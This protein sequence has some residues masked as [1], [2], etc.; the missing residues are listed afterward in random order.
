MDF[1]ARKV[2]IHRGTDDR[3]GDGVFDVQNSEEIIASW[4]L[5]LQETPA[6]QCEGGS[7]PR[8]N[9]MRDVGRH[10]MGE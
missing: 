1:C 7:N 3:M 9:H 8:G 4:S 10:L 5:E 2:S 6:R